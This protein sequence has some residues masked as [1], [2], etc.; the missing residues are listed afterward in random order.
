MNILI[1]V[2]I[3][4]QLDFSYLPA[5]EHFVQAVMAEAYIR[6]LN[7]NESRFNNYRGYDNE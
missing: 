7:V 1:Q 5:Q 6:Q 3:S 2:I 4:L